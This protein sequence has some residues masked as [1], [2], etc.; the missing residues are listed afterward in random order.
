MAHHSKG[1]VFGHPDMIKQY[2]VC[3]ADR[4][5]LIPELNIQE[6]K[7]Y[8]DVWKSLNKR[9]Q[10]RMVSHSSYLG[11]KNHIWKEISHI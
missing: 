1:R 11:V 7:V 10:Q 4:I 6:P 9:F 8:F 3:L 2:A 5:K